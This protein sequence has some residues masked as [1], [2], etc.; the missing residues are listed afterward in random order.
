MEGRMASRSITRVLALLV[1]AG[2]SGC[3][4]DEGGLLT[5]AGRADED[6]IYVA[7]VSD[8]REMVIY[9][10]NGTTDGVSVVEW[11]QG[12]H[13]D[14]RFELESMR[15]GARADG[16]FDEHTGEGVL[17]IADEEI[18]F[19]YQ[20]A[21]GDGGLYFDEITLD[22][23]EHWAGWAVLDDGRLRGSVL[24]RKTGSIAAAGDATPGGKVTV[25]ALAFDVLR[26]EAPAL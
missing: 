23:E 1:L 26:L 24:N 16:S 18:P 20:V 3:T 10:C 22:D 4:D 21:E 9:A 12:P 25:G 17:T 7:L 2:S 13:E 14:G 19:Y 6:E 8:D 11:F 15:T 5:M